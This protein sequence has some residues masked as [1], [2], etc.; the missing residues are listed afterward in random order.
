MG[1]LIVTKVLRVGGVLLAGAVF[2]FIGANIGQA[3]QGRPVGAVLVAVI[4]LAIGG[5]LR[6]RVAQRK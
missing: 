6:W 1:G 2:S 5:V 4:V 3:L